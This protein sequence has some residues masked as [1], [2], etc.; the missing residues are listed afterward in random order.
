MYTHIIRRLLAD[1]VAS[2]ELLLPFRTDALAASDAAGAAEQ[3][4]VP[5][6]APLVF[7]AAEFGGFRHTRPPLELPA[8]FEVRAPRHAKP[9]PFPVRVRVRVRV[10]FVVLCVRLP[11]CFC[12][13]FRVWACGGCRA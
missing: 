13:L 12:V 7:D 1:G 10:P 5:L 8:E 4:H 9:R 11:L 2:D 6:L 3:P